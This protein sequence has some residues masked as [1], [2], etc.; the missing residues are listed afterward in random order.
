ML[1][2]LSKLALFMLLAL[3]AF[4]SGIQTSAL[5]SPDDEP[6]VTLRC[7]KLVVMTDKDVYQSGENAIISGQVSSEI[8]KT[9]EPVVIQVL[10]PVEELIRVKVNP[11]SDG[12]FAYVLSFDADIFVI[13]SSYVV[14]A[15]YDQ[16]RE[17]TT[18]NF[19]PDGIVN[20]ECGFFRVCQYQFSFNNTRY[21][22]DYNLNGVIQDIRLNHDRNS[23]VID[24]LVYSNASFLDVALNP[25]LIRATEL[26]ENGE[27]RHLNFTVLVNGKN[28]EKVSSTTPEF[29]NPTFDRRVFISKLEEGQNSVEIIGTKVIPEFQSLALM[30]MTGTVAGLIVW[31]RSTGRMNI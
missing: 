15:H 11:K 23:L 3:I 7:Q 26:D 16:Q 30:I 6:C 25:E 31:T 27:E 19:M 18:F 20:Y 24:A 22:V 29:T 12:T 14:Y 21:E 28:A 4:M 13:P 2:T 9:K 5:A 17:S 8:F 10:S 1:H